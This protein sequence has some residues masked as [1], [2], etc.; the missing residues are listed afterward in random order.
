MTTR[1]KV[2][3]SSARYLRASIP[4]SADPT[5]DLRRTQYRNSDPARVGGDAGPV[6][7]RSGGERE[8]RVRVRSDLDR[9]AA[10]RAVDRRLLEAVHRHVA[11][12]PG[13]FESDHARSLALA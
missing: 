7:A 6:A 9:D 8:D 11:I 5:R 13:A 4:S 3:M 12:A 1:M 10:L 2:P